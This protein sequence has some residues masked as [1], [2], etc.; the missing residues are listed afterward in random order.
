MSE[1]DMFPALSARLRDCHPELTDAHRVTMVGNRIDLFEEPGN[2]PDLEQTADETAEP[3][4]SEVFRLGVKPP[5]GFCYALLTAPGDGTENV[6][7]M[8]SV[9]VYHEC[10]K[11]DQQGKTANG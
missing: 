8:V 11:L 4:D 6:L 9:D 1:V 2:L 10:V 5:E 3:L 7:V